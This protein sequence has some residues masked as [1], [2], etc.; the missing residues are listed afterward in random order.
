VHYANR[1]IVLIG[2][3]GTG[4]SSV[5]Q[6]LANKLGW[7]IFDTDKMVAK[8]CG[9]PINRIFAETGEE[10]F[11]DEESA[12][13][14]RIDGSQRSVIVTG[15]GV[16]LRTGNIALLRTLGR[17]VCLNADREAL[18]KRLGDQLDRPLLKSA[19]PVARIDQL[20]LER[21]PLYE[22]AAEFSID[23][24]N[25]APEEV[26]EKICHALAHAG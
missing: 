25:S 10:R 6:L 24:S 3:M 1:S 7:P 21:G 9:M 15:G 20:L 22:E 12:A 11:R 5:G 13:L 17:I 18:L 2:F 16:V 23:T 26:V 8:V 14:E 4:K 19:D